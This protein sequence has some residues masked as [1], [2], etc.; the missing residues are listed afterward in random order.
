MHTPCTPHARPSP[1]G[2]PRDSP[3]FVTFQVIFCSTTAPVPAAFPEVT[4]MVTSRSAWVRSWVLPD[5][6]MSTKSAHQVS[7]TTPVLL[8]LLQPDWP[9][10]RQQTRT[11]SR[12]APDPEPA[13]RYFGRSFFLAAS[14][15]FLRFSTICL[16]RL[17][18]AGSPRKRSDRGISIS[19]S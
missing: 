10:H 19:L 11:G 8:T 1:T 16:N 9:L 7:P 17:L 15:E 4:S 12:P 14:A 6:S 13:H 5:R 3:I 18:F 2:A